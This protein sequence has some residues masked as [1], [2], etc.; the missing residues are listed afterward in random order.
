MRQLKALFP[1]PKMPGSPTTPKGLV[2]LATNPRRHS[3]F[4]GCPEEASR[5]E[6]CLFAHIVKK[7]K[8]PCNIISLKQTPKGP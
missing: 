7:K 1:L 3:N 6:N 8:N 5:P 2:D 4:G